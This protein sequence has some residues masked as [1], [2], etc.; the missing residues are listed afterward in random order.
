MRLRQ[1]I[2]LL[3]ERFPV[4][5]GYFR[6]LI[7]SRIHFPEVEMRFLNGLKKGS[8]DIAIDVGAAT[9]SYTWI[10]NRK[11]RQVYA[12]EP[13][14][15]HGDELEATSL[16][17]RVKVV[18]A[19]VGDRCSTVKMFT[20]GN[21]SVALHSATLSPQ[22]PVAQQA[23]A[24]VRDVQQV[25]LD[26]YF[27][28]RVTSDRSVD[29]LKVDVEGYEIEVLRGAMQLIQ[30]YRPLIFC[31]IEKRHNAEYQKFF[32]MLRSAGYVSYIFRNDQFNE[33]SGDTI[34]DLQSEAALRTRLDG[35]YDPLKNDYVNNFVF[36]HEQSRLKVVKT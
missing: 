8:V 9:G 30:K 4:L 26:W 17:S 25:S 14:L 3:L 7:W 22:N 15:A 31:E 20:A 12:F 24:V 27:K 18:R 34:D 6:R 28:G 16:A 2:R 10:L 35:T 19:A 1:R 32:S 13:G 23:L 11:S 33:F 21:D 29:I 36:Q 5:D